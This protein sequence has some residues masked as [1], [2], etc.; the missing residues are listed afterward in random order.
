SAFEMIDQRDLR[1]FLGD[2]QG[3]WENRAVRAMQ[4]MKAFEWQLDFDTARHIKK[5]PGTDP[6]SMERGEFLA[7]EDGLLAH[8]MPAKEVG[9][10]GRGLG[11]RQPDAPPTFQF[12]REERAPEKLI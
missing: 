6:S 10:F 5:R 4:P 1:H 7:A 8:E 2:Q 3:M 9:V 11:E 12:A